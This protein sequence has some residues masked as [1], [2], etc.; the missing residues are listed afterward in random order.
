MFHS[1]K[2]VTKR[3]KE[4]KKKKKKKKKKMKEG[5]KPKEK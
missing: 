3:T 1:K 2:D 5:N 4:Q